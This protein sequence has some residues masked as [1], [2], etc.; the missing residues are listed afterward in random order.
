MALL[1]ATA[2]CVVPVN[3]Q[4]ISDGCF[5][6]VIPDEY[7]SSGGTFYASEKG[8]IML[9]ASNNSIET[10]EKFKQFLEMQGDSFRNNSNSYTLTYGTKNGIHY[11]KFHGFYDKGIEDYFSAIVAGHDFNVYGTNATDAVESIANS[12]SVITP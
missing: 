3:A 11:I 10:E 12:I 4:T 2:T 1:I 6:F 5:S 8:S 7:E 9:R